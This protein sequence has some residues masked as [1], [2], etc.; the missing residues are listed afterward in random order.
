MMGKARNIRRTLGAIGAFT[1]ALLTG[2]VL[3]AGTG[4]DETEV[5]GGVAQFEVGTNF[6]AIRVHGKS[7]ALQGRALVRLKPDGL[8][9]EELRASVPVQTLSTGMSLRDGHMRK[10]IFTTA[11]GRLPDLEFS[12]TSAVCTGSTERADC[13]LVGHLTIRGNTQPFSIAVVAT[14]HDSGFRVVGESVVRLSSYGIE[15]PS[16]LGVRTED[17][18]KLSVDLVARS[19]RSN[20]L[21]TEISR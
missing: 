20:A 5:R 11:D 1:A 2:P 17:E 9:I 12:A 19:V 6:Q 15:P 14:R 13:R 18:V 4:V 16:Q 8:A 7:K 3:V 10:Y 21:L